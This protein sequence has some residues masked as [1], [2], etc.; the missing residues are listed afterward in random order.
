MI[1]AKITEKTFQKSI[2]LS[3]P[4]SVP[5][6]TSVLH[7]RMSTV[8]CCSACML[9]KLNL[10]KL[11]NLYK[12]RILIYSGHILAHIFPKPQNLAKKTLYDHYPK[13]N[14]RK[15]FKSSGITKMLL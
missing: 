15:I 8:L 3:F 13:F 4:L 9:A 7:I 12:V 2:S 11:W 14:F 6:F 5:Y 10:L 1:K